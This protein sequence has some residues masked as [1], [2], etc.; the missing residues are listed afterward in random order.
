MEMK[1][2]NETDFYKLYNFIPN[3]FDNL[4][5]TLRKKKKM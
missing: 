2:L 1:S 5:G 4:E 3:S